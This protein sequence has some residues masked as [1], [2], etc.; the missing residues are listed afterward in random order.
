M[1]WAAVA[2]WIILIAL[3]ATLLIVW[4]AAITWMVRHW[5]PSSKKRG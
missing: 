2:L 5:P 3:W 4:A 1:E